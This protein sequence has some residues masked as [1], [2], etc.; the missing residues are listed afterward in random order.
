M[1][2]KDIRDYS[3]IYLSIEPIDFRKAVDG[4]AHAVRQELKMD[5]FG[6]YLFLFCNKHRKIEMLNIF[7]HQDNVNPFILSALL[8]QNRKSVLGWKGSIRKFSF[9]IPASPSIPRRKSV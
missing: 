8:P 1:I 5:P 2:L 3:G 6:N 9:T 4:L 7:R